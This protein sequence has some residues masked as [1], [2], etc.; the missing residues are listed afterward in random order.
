MGGTIDGGKQAAATNKY[1]Y[2]V[3]FYKKIGGK[4]GKISR[5]GGFASNRAC[6]CELSNIFGPSHLKAQCAGSK[7]GTTSRRPKMA[8]PAQIPTF[9]QEFDDALDE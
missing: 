1:R 9:T 8:K 4:G 7:G 6:S 5:G 2:G 3:N